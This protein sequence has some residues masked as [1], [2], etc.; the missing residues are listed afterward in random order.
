[1]SDRLLN[2][3]G[4]MLTRDIQR[5]IRRNEITPS[6][7]STG[8]TLVRSTKLVNSIRHIVVGDKVVV[9]SNLVYARI[10]HEGGIIRP[11][12]AKALAIPIAKIAATKNP[13]DFDNTF[14]KKGII[15]QKQEDG[16]LLALY[17]LKKSVTIPARPYMNIDPNAR[18]SM[19]QMLID[20]LNKE[21]K[22]EL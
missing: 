12:N 18:E 11:V 3:L 1:M 9:G 13:R 10:H 21:I 19:R 4:M 6:S 16:S 20:H 14:I 8:T 5:R 15:F 7:K 22:K 2:A 17:A